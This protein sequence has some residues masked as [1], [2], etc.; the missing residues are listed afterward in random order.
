M[1]NETTRIADDIGGPA[2]LL[3]R[4]LTYSVWC[5]VVLV[6][7]QILLW[8]PSLQQVDVFSGARILIAGASIGLL[9]LLIYAR[10]LAKLNQLAHAIYVL[11]GGIC[12]IAVLTVFTTPY[13]LSLALLP[14]TF[15]LFLAM[16]FVGRKAYWRMVWVVIA[17]VLVLVPMSGFLAPTLPVPTTAVMLVQ[18]VPLAAAMIMI[19]TMM[20]MMQG[21]MSRTMRD[22][23]EA[24]SSL[25]A[26][27]ASRTAELQVAHAESQR[28]NDERRQIEARLR[29]QTA[30]LDALHQTSLAILNRMDTDL[31]LDAIITNACKLL[32]VRHGVLSL[33]QPDQSCMTT[34]FTRGYFQQQEMELGHKLVIQRGEGAVGLSWQLNRPLKINNY[35]E[36]PH[37]LVEVRPD[38]FKGLIISPLR[39]EDEVIGAISVANDVDQPD[40]TDDDLDLLCRYAQI[41]SIAI[42]NARL[43]EATRANEQVLEQR[44][45]DRTGELSTLLG[46]A[47]N[48]SAT[49]DLPALL[50]VIFQQI[51]R[52]IDH[53]AGTI[54][55]V[56]DDYLDT[57]HYAGPEL[58]SYHAGI[59]WRLSGHHLELVRS[60]RPIIVGDV[61]SDEPMAVLFRKTS[62]QDWLGQVPAHIVSWIGVPM[63]V[64]D[65]VIGILTLDSATPNAF[66]ERHAEL[67]MAI[68]QQAALALENARLY[69]RAG[70]AAAQA[71]RT[72]LA[73]DL[74]DSVSQAV[75]GIV[76]ASRTIEKIVGPEDARLAVPL[77]HILALSDA[78]M[79]EIRALIFELRPESLESEGILAALNKQADA[80]RARYGLPV[81]IEPC[82][83][84]PEMPLVVKVAIYRIAQEAMHNTVKHA[85]ARHLWLSLHCHFDEVVLEV[86]DDGVG[87]DPSHSVPGHMGLI[88]MRERAASLGGR[89]EMLS[90]RGQGT[91]VRTVIP[92]QS[93]DALTNKLEMFDAGL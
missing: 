29:R 41:V 70:Q 43:F 75:Y 27:V 31:L 11:F 17:M 10:R 21:W 87:F 77:Q 30:Y 20:G 60:G 37:R 34:D 61:H 59:K 7:V 32:N 9:A 16:P 67:L 15:G 92:L 53:D 63:K 81:S 24:Q 42:D 28:E 71:E 52:L 64:K 14:P 68:A 90:V 46:V 54:F 88:T 89:V 45:A 55:A 36:W 50:R 5:V 72:R 22:L 65:R 93:P 73:R 19:L 91:L 86:R 79:A 13:A 40:F 6:V 56:H 66:T 4:I 76:L 33:M 74:H 8:A 83:E 48:L 1:S 57:L 35:A 25:E 49:L 69:N 51:S 44:V 18:T 26:K 80:I 85:Q 23:R 82:P 12:V 39:R 3:Q 84:E 58:A 47:Q 78:A 2:G 62:E 38:A